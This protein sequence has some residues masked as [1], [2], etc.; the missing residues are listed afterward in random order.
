MKSRFIKT[1]RW[2]L[3]KHKKSRVLPGVDEDK[4]KYIKCWNCGFIINTQRGLNIGDGS[5]VTITDFPNPDL[6]LKFMGR[7]LSIYWDTPFII[8]Y[9]PK[10][11]KPDGNPDFDIYTPREAEVI[12]GC[13]FCGCKNLP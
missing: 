4:G 11:D 10:N 13:P 5:G 6:D 2:K 7:V 9:M 3:P 8:G 12:G 1:T